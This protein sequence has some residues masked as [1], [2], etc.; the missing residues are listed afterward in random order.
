V[1]PLT[2]VVMS[3]DDQ[4]CGVE[5]LPCGLL[6]FLLSM[7]ASCNER[8]TEADKWLCLPRAVFGTKISWSQRNSRL[9]RL[10]LVCT[11]W[12][13]LLTAT[14]ARELV[15]M[16]M[17]NPASKA[18]EFSTAWWSFVTV[19]RH[20]ALADDS[21]ILSLLGRC[22]GIRSLDLS[23]CRL[24]TDNGVRRVTESC[25][26]LYG[27]DLSRCSGL[28]D[29]S[30]EAIANGCKQILCI[31]LACCEQIT[32][33]GVALLSQCTQLA[34]LDLDNC[35]KVSDWGVQQI[36]NGCKHLARLHIGKTEV[37]NVSKLVEQCL[38]LRFIRFKNC[39]G[40]PGGMYRNTSVIEVV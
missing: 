35:T 4:G 7:T 37:T 6:E 39:Q 38:Q 2:C 11:S 13:E 26:R 9:N 8:P 18:E 31:R 33:A 19:Y 23:G 29:A 32:D 34:Y 1:S 17:A 20:T 40:I 15:R 12:H 16:V 10:A 3:S 24:L 14:E 22:S 25:P 28:T 5:R 30:C 27:L 21:N 36:A